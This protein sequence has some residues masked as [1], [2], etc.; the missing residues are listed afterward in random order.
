[1]DVFYY[2]NQNSSSGSAFTFSENEIILDEE[3]NEWKLLDANSDGIN[4]G[5]YLNADTSSSVIPITN[6]ADGTYS[7]VN[8]TLNSLEVYHS[9]FDDLEDLVNALNLVD[10]N[11]N[12]ITQEDADAIV[13]SVQTKL[14]SAYDAQNV[15]HSIVGTRTNTIET[16]SDI[17]QSKLTN[18][19]ILE[20]EYASADLTALAIEAQSLENTYT[21]LYST[22][23]RVNNLSL[24]QYLN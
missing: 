6:N 4:D 18:L 14:D 12:S 22:I 5:L 21:A 2:V 20:E 19:A 13:A 17:V 23:N 15:S 24:I 10:S 1:M 11:G 16:Y 9:I 8:S 3:G 7:A